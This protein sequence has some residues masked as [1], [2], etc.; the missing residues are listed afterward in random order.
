MEIKCT[1]QELRE[2]IENKKET[3]VAGTTDVIVRIDE[4][5][6][7]KFAINTPEDTLKK[8]IFDSLTIDDKHKAN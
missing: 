2:L 5:P 7:T 8:I 3:P 6:T 1:V 4:T